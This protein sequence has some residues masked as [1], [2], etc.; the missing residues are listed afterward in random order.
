[1]VRKPCVEEI[2]KTFKVIAP[3]LV[4]IAVIQAVIAIEIFEIN[5]S[6]LKNE[7]PISRR[8]L[9]SAVGSQIMP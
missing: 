8:V 1:M 6:Q 5:L 9:D 3:V 2:E 7:C 4:V